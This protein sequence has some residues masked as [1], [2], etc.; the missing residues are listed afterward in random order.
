MDLS[1]HDALR[2]GGSQ[3]AADGLLKRDFM[4]SLEKESYDD[5]VGETVAKTDYR[6]LVDGKDSKQG[7]GLMMSAGQ[8][9]MLRQE[10]QG[11][12]RPFPPGQSAFSSD[13]MSGPVSMMGMSDQWGNQNK[14][15]DSNMPE[16][17][18]GFSQPGM[19]MNMN[20]GGGGMSPFQ[21]GLSSGMADTQK[22]SPP[23]GSEP[24]KQTPAAPAFKS[25]DP[26]PSGPTHNPLDQFSEGCPPSQWAGESRPQAPPAPPLSPGDSVDESPPSSTSEPLSPSG[27]SVEEKGGGG[28]QQKRKKKKRRPRDEVYNFLDRQEAQGDG[29]SESAASDNAALSPASSPQEE[30]PW[31]WEIRGRGGGGGGRVKGRKN[32]SRMKLPEEWGAPQEPAS[33]TPASVAPGWATATDTGPVAAS[34]LE[35]SLSS[36]DDPQTGPFSL[37]DCKPNAAHQ[38]DSSH[39]LL[40]NS[41]SL[42]LSPGMPSAMSN[43]IKPD[44]GPTEHTPSSPR[45]YEPM[46]LDDFPM[47]SAVSKAAPQRQGLAGTLADHGQETGKEQAAPG[48]PCLSPVSQTF[49]FLD[50]VL[51]T[52]PAT[53]PISQA[54]PL[55]NLSTPAPLS[56]TSA[57]PTQTSSPFDP[58]SPTL[59]HS[60]S[61]NLTSSLLSSTR[62]PDTSLPATASFGLNPA[63]PPFIPSAPPSLSAAT[64]SIPAAP[65][66]PSP[67]A[68]TE[69]QD[70]RAPQLPPLE[71][72]AD[73]KEKM[74]KADLFPKV[75]KTESKTESKTENKTESKTESKTH[76]KTE[77][78]QDKQEKMDHLD[79]KEKEDP[80]KKVDSSD[81]TQ[82]S[83]SILKEEKFDKA[84]KAE[85]VDKP[86]K[87]DKDEKME[88]KEQAEKVTDKTGK[89]EKEEKAGKG[90][91]KSPTTNGSKHLASPDSKTKP[92]AGSTKPNSAKTR[93]TSLSTDEAANKKTPVNKAPT[94]TAGAKRPTSRTPT[95]STPRDTKSKTE[96]GTAERRPPVPKATP[97]ARASTNK[98]GS[99]ANK[100]ENKTGEAKK[101]ST[102]KPASATRPRA[103]RTPAAPPTPPVTNGEAKEPRRRI[104][105]PPV[106]KQ[107]VPEK[108]PP[109][110]R[111]PRTNRPLNAPTPDLKNV[112]S[113][114]GSTDNMKYQPGGG[115]VSSSQGKT[116][117]KQT[118]QAKVQIV[119]KKLDFSHIT[120]RCGSK[121]NI[122]HVPGGGN[123][124][125][126]SK[127]VDLS[128][129]TSKC[130]SKDN[131]KHKPGG[132][133]KIE[134]NKVNTKAKSKIGSLEN[135]GEEIG[136]GDN[137][138]E[139]VREKAMGKTS[140]PGGA[141]AAPPGSMTKE[142]GLK[143]AT[144]TPFGGE[145]LR[146]TLG[147]D[148]RIPETN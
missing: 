131:I 108:K 49:S 23:F 104:T 25:S 36:Q 102:P 111:A 52:T 93:P 79:K 18:L 42:S 107:T 45:P 37:T 68:L 135:V 129:V 35:D 43:P 100:T 2:D 31:E 3:S 64:T 118:G 34:A 16:S 82:K 1:L 110:P 136:N 146:D 133:V 75:D 55:V 41:D 7:S 101:P 138:A 114:I 117:A 76:I 122:K 53:T 21:T 109:V 85:K 13:Y 106:P 119:H 59:Q 127:K 143:Q 124:Q 147:M 113:K 6:P 51:Q 105:K 137:K 130:G 46:C 5:K 120:S 56:Q 91:A 32:K 81:Q 9:G 10:P 87:T 78:K 19:M 148:K 8:T 96:N 11:E 39:T 115:R 26:F 145:G 132:D 58:V 121:D 95:S 17:L 139:E 128:K 142:N 27:G 112:R 70:P 29:Q 54:T 30:E 28:K 63:A 144:P 125:I 134:S 116:D 74:E 24:P 80:L 99:P 98:N 20:L 92:A 84:E 65:P 40:G 71:V 126:L 15:K 123:V 22:T 47:S 48:S 33:P 86:E 73:N 140:P 61:A 89:A 77:N 66:S 57:H 60:S 38:I 94:P 14:M 83:Q 69:H 97:S 103:P 62:L 141:P 88:K 44:Q 12:K 67:P 72:K 90:T 4:S 50:S